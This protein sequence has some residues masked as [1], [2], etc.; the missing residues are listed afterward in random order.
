MMKY[1]KKNSI[2][3]HTHIYTHIHI[4]IDI[5]KKKM[6][7]T[8]PLFLNFFTKIQSKGLYHFFSFYFLI[9]LTWFV[10]ESIKKSSMIDA[11]NYEDFNISNNIYNLITLYVYGF[12][13]FTIVFKQY[14]LYFFE[15]ELLE[16][17]T[18]Y[19]T[20]Y[21][22]THTYKIPF[23]S[24][25]YIVLTQAA[26]FTFANLGELTFLQFSLSGNVESKL[27]L[28]Y[29]ALFVFIP[30][31]VVILTFFI[32]K[33]INVKQKHKLASFLFPIIISTLLY[34][35]MYMQCAEENAECGFH[36]HHAFLSGFIFLFTA[37]PIPKNKKYK[38]GKYTFILHY[39]NFV[40]QSCSLGI[41]VEGIN[42][43]GGDDL[44]ILVVKGGQSISMWSSIIVCFIL[45]LIGI[46]IFVIGIFT[47]PKKVE[48]NE[49][50]LIQI[51]K[52][53]TD[54]SDLKQYKRIRF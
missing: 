4:F 37:Q 13:L 47:K 11:D 21:K 14:F 19:K 8:K 45:I 7:L 33:I 6:F 2:Y 24:I 52:N 22:L 43:F 30:L 1:E 26:S 46:G 15:N 16:N 23:D 5:L 20:F 49:L 3:T 40:I 28:H 17:S 29:D 18:S 35:M 50:E 36:L 27:K 44:R 54:G 39:L 31:I 10:T 34:A 41:F 9:T 53:K 51:K 12:V 38:D 42:F 48:D 32:W 25:L